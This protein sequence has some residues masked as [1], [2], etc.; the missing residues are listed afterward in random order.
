MVDLAN[1]RWGQA[2]RIAEKKVE[3]TRKAFR[4][5]LNRDEWRKKRERVWDKNHKSEYSHLSN[6]P[7][8]LTN[9]D[10]PLQE[11]CVFCE[12]TKRK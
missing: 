9:A 5:A 4:A 3:K 6:L 1:Y 8:D 7:Q 2:E 12:A 11:P 10:I